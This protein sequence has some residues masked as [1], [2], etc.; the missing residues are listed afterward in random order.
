MLK[1]VCCMLLVVVL[2]SLLSACNNSQS[3]LY[4]LNE[5]Y[6]LGW[7]TQDNIME[8]CY[9]RFGEVWIGEDEN[10]DTWVKIEYTP[11]NSIINLDKKEEEAI[12]ETYYKLNKSKFFD[13]QGNSIGGINDIFV[14]FFGVY[15]N[16]YI[17]TITCSLWDLGT[18]VTPKVLAGVAW[19]ESDS[20]FIVYK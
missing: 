12:K 1:K 8:V 18:A 19:W 6:D 4:S 7:I 10:Y 17:V 16:A 15:N 3:K 5:A 2:F 13:K 20:G 9:N 11:N 14:N